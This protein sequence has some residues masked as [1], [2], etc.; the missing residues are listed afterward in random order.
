MTDL[1]SAC[2]SWR[3]AI[4]SLGLPGGQGVGDYGK[5]S[6]FSAMQPGSEE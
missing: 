1:F 4:V 5:Y 6:S 2:T 3:T